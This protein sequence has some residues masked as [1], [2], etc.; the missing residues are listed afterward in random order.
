MTRPFFALSAGLMAVLLGFRHARALR[1][2][3]QVL[4]RWCE[5]LTHLALLLGEAVLSLPEAMA[6]AAD[7]HLPPDRQIK[8]IV[9]AME[10]D[11]LLS[12]PDAFDKLCPPGPERET[13]LRMAAGIS[14]GSAQNR[15]LAAEQSAHIIHAKAQEAAQKAGKDAR[16]FQTLGWTGGL[17]LML[18]LL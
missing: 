11:R 13:L 5:I 4:L 10:Q 12:L 17:T 18:M 16:L 7:G 6:C 3:A 14:R 2:D 15:Q 9:Q 1:Q 8:E